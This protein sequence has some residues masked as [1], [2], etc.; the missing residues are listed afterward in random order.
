[1]ESVSVEK[2]K[3]QLASNGLFLLAWSCEGRRDFKCD[4]C[5]KLFT[6][7]GSLKRHIQAIH[8]DKKD[9]KCDYC[10]N[11]YSVVASFNRHV[12]KNHSNKYDYFS[13]I[14]LYKINDIIASC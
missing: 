1:M 8:E 3:I 4:S 5:G 9:Y 13:N 11:L 10:G 14:I 6:E 2:Q 12:R 7:S